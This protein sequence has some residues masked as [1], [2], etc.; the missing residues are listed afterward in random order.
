MK[1]KISEFIS[2]YLVKHAGDEEKIEKFSEFIDSFFSNI[3]EEH[4]EVHTDFYTEVEDFTEEIDEAM[5]V[6]I[7]DSLRHKDGTHVGAKWTLEEVSTVAKQYDVK[8][9]IEACGK[10]FCCDKFWLALNYVFAV[11]YSINR[12]INGYIDLAIDEYCNKNICFD[13]II[14]TIFAKI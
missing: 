4:S 5:M 14:K 2:G 10:E 6:E 9:K 11:H 1:K 8:A 12:T 13:K 7:V 3:S